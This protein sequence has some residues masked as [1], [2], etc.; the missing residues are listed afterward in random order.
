MIRVVATRVQASMTC[1]LPDCGR[2]IRL[3]ERPPDLAQDS[4]DQDAF[5]TTAETLGWSIDPSG[6]TICPNHPTP[7]KENT[8]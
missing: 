3:P 8:P 6:L 4:A 7:P 5:K 2:A 1:D